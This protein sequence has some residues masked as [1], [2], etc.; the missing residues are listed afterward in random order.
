[1]M[2][3]INTDGEIISG[4]YGGKPFGV[5][6]NEERYQAMLRLERKSASIEKIEEMKELLQEFEGLTKEDFKQIVETASPYIYVNK[7]T[8]QFYLKHK[9][10]IS[11]KAI[12][13]PLVNRMLD[14][15]EKK[16]DITPLVKCW[17]RFMRNI[18]FTESKARRFA[19][20]INRTHTNHE[21]VAE[22]QEQGLSHEVATKLATTMQTPIT[23]EGLLC[24][25]KVST[26]IDWKYKLDDQGQPV[27]VHRHADKAQ[28]DEV[29][30]LVTYAGIDN[31]DRLFQP[32]V[33]GTGGDEFFCGDELGHKIRVGKAH[34]LPDWS[35]VNTDDNQSCVPGL[36][37]G[38]IDYIKGY[39][40]AGTVTHYVFV[41]PM[42]IGAI[43]DEDADSA[44]RVLQYFVYD[45]FIGVNR[46]YYHSSQYAKKTDEEYDE[47]VR[48][49]VADSEGELDAV[50]TVVEE[51]ENLT[52]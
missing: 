23:Q 41:D 4:S 43:T 35:Y 16:I 3:I 49:A 10:K 39:Q 36:H 9:D 22:L 47:M 27:K 31:E 37:V 1:M 12:P 15:V 40:H 2:I 33:M 44:L 11:T 46:G 21:R 14:S 6:F 30:G 29:T 48:Q 45:S 42:H 20:Y 38:N 26:E 52:F 7:N 5:T 19:N 34:R 17:V 25:Y 50:R 8:G 24:T 28:I 18:N 13:Q 32:A 51:K